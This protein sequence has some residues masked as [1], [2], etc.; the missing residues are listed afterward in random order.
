ML[1]SVKTPPSIVTVTTKVAVSHNPLASHTLYIT[2]SIPLKLVVLRSY[3]ML[4]PFNSVAVPFTALVIIAVVN[5]SPLA[6]LSFACTVATT[7]VTAQLSNVKV[8]L[9]LTAVGAVGVE[10]CIANV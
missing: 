8:T 7:V 1:N 10:P 2:E 9:S 3:K 6:S 5:A 4:S